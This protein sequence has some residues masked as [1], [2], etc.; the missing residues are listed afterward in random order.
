VT[1]VGIGEDPV[2]DQII[3]DN[4]VTR[5]MHTFCT[6]RVIVASDT[7]KTTNGCLT[8]MLREPYQK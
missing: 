7:E 3:I 2:E 8:S 5:V 1:I 6:M 4:R